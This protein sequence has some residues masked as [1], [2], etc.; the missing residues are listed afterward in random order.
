MME[1]VMLVNLKKENPT[2]LEKTMMLRIIFYMK[3]N[4]KKV[5][6]MARELFY[7]LGEENLLVNL[8][9]VNFMKVN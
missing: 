7:L 9:K 1:E 4:M 5:I 3:D 2:D 8:K 6:G